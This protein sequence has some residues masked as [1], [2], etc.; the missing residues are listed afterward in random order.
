MCHNSPDHILGT[1]N[2]LGG[3]DLCPVCSHDVTADGS[4]GVDD[5]LAV[6]SAWGGCVCVE[7]INGD[8][9][10]NVDDLLLVIGDFGPCPTTP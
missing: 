8:S 7:D 10:V 9:V 3:N 5:V 6:V 2:D 1:W 4:V